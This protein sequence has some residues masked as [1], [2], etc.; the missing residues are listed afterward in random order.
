MWGGQ[1]DGRWRQVPAACG[2]LA[3]PGFQ[4]RGAVQAG[5]DAGEDDGEVGG[6]EGSGEPGKSRGGGA[7]LDRAGEVPAVVDQ[8][9]EHAE[10]AADTVG[11]VRAG[12]GCIGVH[13]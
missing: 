3:E 11:R 7:L 4:G 8:P 5:G 10:D 9:A 13:G 1:A 12:P 2:A 6:A